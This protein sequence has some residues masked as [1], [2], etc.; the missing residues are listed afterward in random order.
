[1][2]KKSFVFAAA[3]AAFATSLALASPAAAAFTFD[4]ETGTGFVGKGDVQYTLGWNN[5]QLQAG[6]ESVQFA[7][8]SEV[9]TETSWICTNS[10]NQQQQE[11]ERATTTSI[12]GLVDSIG[13]D[14]K[15]I[16]GFILE[17]YA[18]N[19]SQSSTTEGPAVNTCPNG[20]WTLT[21][22][23]GDPEVVSSTSSLDVSGDNGI[24]WTELLEKP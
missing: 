4:T 10:N 13:R 3:A 22:P 15:Q 9:V 2:N 8:V 19:P 24:T 6:A 17:G 7:S 14:K 21:T 20:P 16:T 5:T 23:A 18:G 11:R 1:M 12:A